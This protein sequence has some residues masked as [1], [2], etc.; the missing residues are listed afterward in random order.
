MYTYMY[1][2][3]YIYIYLYIYVFAYLH[4]H[5]YMFIHKTYGVGRQGPKNFR[6][7]GIF[8]VGAIH[9]ATRCNSLHHIA[10]YKRTQNHSEYLAYVTP[11][12]KH[13]ATHCNTLQHT[14]THCHTLQ[15][16][17]THC[18]TLP[19]KRGTKNLQNIWHI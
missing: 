14:A 4:I 7:S 10:T 5:I 6:I 1:M 13:T 16:T 18:Y 8:D 19:H 3:I 17:A 9:T 2:Y 12:R 15:H 11:V